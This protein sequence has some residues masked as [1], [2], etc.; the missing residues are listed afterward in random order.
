MG[1]ALFSYGV[2][3]SSFPSC[4]PSEVV[5]LASLRKTAWCQLVRRVLRPSSCR[6]TPRLPLCLFS[7][8][9]ASQQI[10]GLYKGMASPIAGVGLINALLFGMSPLPHTL[11]PPPPGCSPASRSEVKQQL[12]AAFSTQRAHVLRGV[13]MQS[14]ASKPWEGHMHSLRE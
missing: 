2:P 6:L 4:F 5:V 10:R 14:I 9:R 7:S 3:Y 13:S 11:L 12:R 1:S 8:I